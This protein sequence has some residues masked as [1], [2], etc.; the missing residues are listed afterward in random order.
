MKEQEREKDCN[1]KKEE[2]MVSFITLYA[3]NVTFIKHSVNLARS[4]S[5]V[6]FS[7]VRAL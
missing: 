6:D 5:E 4:S 3:L 1:E 7:L 2:K